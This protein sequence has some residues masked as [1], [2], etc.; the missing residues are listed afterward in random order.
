MRPFGPALGPAL[1]ILCVLSASGAD[2]HP[3]A[4]IEMRSDVVFDEAGR[5]TALNLDWTFDSEYTAMA[6]EGLDTNGDGYYSAGELEPLAKENIEALKDYDFFVNARA[7]E[8][9]LAFGEVTEYGQIHN[10]GILKMHFTLPFAEPVDPRA[11]EFMYQ[12]YDPT[13]YIA[14]DYPDREAVAVIGPM[15]RGCD[16]DLKPTPSD[17]QTD[18]TRRMLAD[19]DQTWIPPE[20]SD[21]GSLFAQPVVVACGV[22]AAQ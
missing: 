4:W 2:A 11:A 22:V 21:F 1:A 18:A 3:H 15:P 8:R 13:F 10:D 12:V 14:M 16:I 19:K 20:G 17:A 5:I 9:K 6:I 7:G